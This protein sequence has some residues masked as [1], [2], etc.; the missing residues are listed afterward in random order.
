MKSPKEEND[1]SDDF[2]LENSL[3]FKGL[4]ELGKIKDIYKN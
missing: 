4:S 2:I 3:A 1:N